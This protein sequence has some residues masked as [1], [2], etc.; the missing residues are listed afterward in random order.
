MSIVEAITNLKSRVNNAYDAL[1]VKGATIPEVKNTSNLV[2]T[3]NSITGVKGQEDGELII[4]GHDRDGRTILPSIIKKTLINSFNEKICYFTVANS[5]FFLCYDS[6][7]SGIHYSTDGVTWNQSNITSGIFTRIVYGNGKYVAVPKNEDGYLYYSTDGSTWTKSSKICDYHI[8]DVVYFSGKFIICYHSYL[9]YSTDLNTWTDCTSYGYRGSTANF[10][11]KLTTCNNLVFVHMSFGGNLSSSN[12]LNWSSSGYT[13]GGFDDKMCFLNNLYIKAQGDYIRSNTDPSFYRNSTTVA[14]GN[15]E[16]CGP[17]VRNNICFGYSNGRRRFVYTKNGTT[18]TEDNFGFINKGYNF[19]EV[20]NNVCYFLHS[21]GTENVLHSLDSNEPY[22]CIT[23]LDLRTLNTCSDIVTP[24]TSRKTLSVDTSQYI[25][26]DGITIRGYRVRNITVQ[27]DISSATLRAIPYVAGFTNSGLWYSFDGVKWIQSGQ[28]VNTF[29]SIADG[30]DRGLV[31]VRATTYPVMYSSNLTAWTNASTSNLS[32]VYGARVVY[33][34]SKDIFVLGT[35]SGIRYEGSPS[36]SWPISNCTASISELFEYEGHFVAACT[37]GGLWYSENGSEWTQTNKTNG[38]F[39]CFYH[40]SGTFL[41]GSSNEGIWY[42]IDYGKTWFQT[43]KTDGTFYSIIYRGGKYIA[44]SSQGIWYSS[45]F[46]T[47]SQSNITSGA[48]LAILNYI[49]SV[50]ASIESQGIWYTTDNGVTWQQTDKTDGT[51]NFLVR[52]QAKFMAGGSSGIWYSNANG[53]NWYPSNITNKTCTALFAS[54]TADFYYNTITIDPVTSAIDSNIQA[55]NIKE[56]VEILGVTGTLPVLNNEEKTVY[57]TSSFQEVTPST[58]YSGISKV[59]VDKVRSSAITTSA[60]TTSKTIN[61]TEYSNQNHLFIGTS[62]GIWYSLDNGV[63]WTQTNKDSGTIGGLIYA[64][65]KF[66]CACTSIGLWYSTDG[67]NWSESNKNS[68]TWYSVNFGNNTYVACGARVNGIWYSSDG[69]TWVA[70]NKSSIIVYDVA[71]GNGK[72]IAGSNASNGLL[73]SSDGATWSSSNKTDSIFYSVNYCNGRFF[74]GS[75]NSGI[76]Y[77]TDGETWSQT[78][79]TDG[80]FRSVFYA[81]GKYLAGG[82]SSIGIWYSTDG[83]NW[84]QSNKTDLIWRKF[85]Y[86]GG[87]YFGCSQS[88]GVWYSDDGISWT[89]SNDTSLAVYSI[90]GK[91]VDSYFSSVTINPVTASID[92]NIQPENIKSGVTILGVAGT[93]SSSGITPTGNINITSTAQTDVTNYATA[94]VVDSNLVAGNIKKDVQILGVTGTYEGSGGTTP[95]GTK[96]ISVNSYDDFTVDVTNYAYA[97]VYWQE[98]ILKGTLVNLSNGLTKPIEDI[99]YND[100]ILCWDFDEAKYS[101]SKPFWIKRPKTTNHYWINKFKSG[102]EIKTT[103]TV[104]GHRF[105]N[106]DKN[107][108]LYNTDCIGNYCYTVNGNDKLI[109][110]KYVEEECEYYNVMTRHHMNLFAN[111]ILT[112]FRYNNL[113]PIRDMKF[114]KCERPHRDR[115]E[116]KNIPDSWYYGMRCSEQTDSL[117]NIESYVN[118]LEAIR[119]EI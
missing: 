96:D 109:E 28:T 51:F 54:S 27:P 112:G 3:I 31:A 76:W 103:G 94:Q 18:W 69:I 78:N 4:T 56:G 66:V 39:N 86:S 98:C 63:N 32:S 61:A 74:A 80:G 8:K 9:N 117:E 84:T 17:V 16:L 102:L 41:A 52:D 22:N 60:E 35:T 82:S 106:I 13:A 36:G 85:F 65:G 72:F 101:H 95:T 24:S 37:S 21:D 113:Y 2:S 87:K 1:E 50:I 40:Y 44:G 20:S 10:H 97:H 108:F 47:W 75:S 104:A 114:V 25:G 14:I 38:I 116:F 88:A 19:L 89:Q 7:T 91:Q 93:A 59:T 48:C 107:Q 64:N 79:K 90:T 53:R 111:G 46:I 81:N 68:G 12:G 30:K 57:P 83:I 92:S 11:D 55:G 119:K 58:G 26:Y 62:T 67:M 15:L 73:Y 5:K 45:D 49:S 105:F 34:S 29:K 23:K 118:R 77:S 6:L 110:A 99:L 100:E 33:S 43:E 42:S 71:Y 70:S 115:D